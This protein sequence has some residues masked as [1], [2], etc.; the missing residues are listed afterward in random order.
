MVIA[1]WEPSARLDLPASG[2][3]IS[4]QYHIDSRLEAPPTG[5]DCTEN[6]GLGLIM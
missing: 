3:I 6:P 2:G 4:N 5:Q 1:A